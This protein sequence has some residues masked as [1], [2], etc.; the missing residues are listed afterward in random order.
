MSNVHQFPGK[1]GKPPGSELSQADKQRIIETAETLKSIF[2]PLTDDAICAS[3]DSPDGKGPAM[4][5]YKMPII[6][7]RNGKVTHM[8]GQYIDKLRGL[9]RYT[10]NCIELRCDPLGLAVYVAAVK[11]VKDGKV[12][13]GIRVVAYD[14][15]R[16]EPTFHVM[17]R[18]PVELTNKL[19][20]CLSAT[21]NRLSRE[22]NLGG[23][24]PESL[25]LTS[26]DPGFPNIPLV[27][28]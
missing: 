9:R 5:P 17:V 19:Y 28:V 25:K 24:A 7:G 10:N 15:D 26:N 12:V 3:K 8:A 23:L 11:Q 18:T 22:Y 16:V 2:K 14:F 13:A 6:Y 27:R 1:Q 20:T 21:Y 4:G